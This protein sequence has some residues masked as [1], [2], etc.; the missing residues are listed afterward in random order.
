MPEKEAFI[1]VGVVTQGKTFPSVSEIAAIWTTFVLF[2]HLRSFH[3]LFSGISL[4]FL[5]FFSNVTSVKELAV[6][7]CRL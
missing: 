2:S 5:L 6:T 4:R 3:E 7:G 1:A